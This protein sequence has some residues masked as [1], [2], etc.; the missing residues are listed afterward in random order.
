[1]SPAG[2]ELHLGESRG[3]RVVDDARSATAAHDG[4]IKVKVTALT[5][6]QQVGE[7]WVGTPGAV[8]SVSVVLGQN[9]VGDQLR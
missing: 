9:P 4:S 7:G 1:M 2:S 3:I 8:G 6:T 5:A